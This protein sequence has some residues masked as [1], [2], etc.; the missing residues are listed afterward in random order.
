MM[1]GADNNEIR[2]KLARNTRTPIAVLEML[3]KREFYGE[4]KEECRDY[5]IPPR[6][7]EE[8][9][10]S[11]AFNPNLTSSILAKLAQ[12]PSAKIRS[13]L[14][15]HP[16]MTSE[17]W[18]QIAQ[19]EDKDVREYIASSIDTPIHILE[20]LALDTDTEVRQK[21]AANPNT[22][23]TSLDILYQDYMAEV[24]TAVAG[25]Q[26]SNVIVLEQLGKDEKVEVRR[27]VA[28]NPNTPAPLQESLKDLLDLPYVPR[29]IPKLSPTLAGVSRIY[30]PDTDDLATLLS[31]YAKSDNAFVRFVTL[32]HP[33]T[34]V[35][36]ITEGCQSLFWQERYA[37]ADNSSTPGEIL[38]QLAND[39]NRIVRAT[40]KANL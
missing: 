30:K 3:A 25:N 17:L 7:V 27:A 31:E 20:T 36:S 5:I 6:T 39:S 21:V 24:R 18:Q 14:V 22:P 10:E 2:R 23:T 13:L 16:N 40:A 9:L 29:Y 28:K 8:V 32:M 33:L 35:D 12:D 4:E 11:L 1:A 38:E 19:D 15:Y 37:V 34:P 26:N